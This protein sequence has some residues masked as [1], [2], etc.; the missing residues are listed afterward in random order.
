MSKR[1]RERE[2]RVPGSHLLEGGADG[3]DEAA[4]EVKEQD[5]DVDSLV[6]AVGR[7]ETWHP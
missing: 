2:G 6:R 7:V 3:D 4:D 5:G 1:W